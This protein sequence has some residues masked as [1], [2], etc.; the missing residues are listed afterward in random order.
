[1]TS[2][3][4]LFRNFATHP[5]LAMPE[6]VTALHYQ[7][8][9]GQQ[10]T[11]VL[12]DNSVVHLNT[13][14][15]VTIRYS[16]T[17]R[18]VNLAAGEAVFEVTHE[19]GRPFRVTAKSAQITDLGTRFDVRLKNATTLVTVV[20]GRVEVRPSST[21]AAKRDGLEVDAGQQVSVTDGGLPLAP[22]SAN[23]GRAT[24][25]LHRQISFDREPLQ[26]VAEEFNRYAMKSIEITTPALRSLQVSGI[27]TTDD[28]AA[29]IAFLRSLDGVQVEETASRIV[30]SEQNQR[31]G[32]R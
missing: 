25:W 20:E 8:G 4:V 11:Y 24:A 32:V 10:Q 26:S 30:V 2:G 23:T 9:H 29:F 3:L 13:D 21:M 16:K 18:A 22:V 7:T 28:T 19:S 31:P 1:V 6:A 12:A 17:E 14:S 5:G 15:N 27:F